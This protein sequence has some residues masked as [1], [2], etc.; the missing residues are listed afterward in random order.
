MPVNAETKPVSG[1][2]EQVAIGD[3]KLVLH[4]KIDTG[5]KNSSLN[6]KDFRI[7]TKQGEDWVSFSIRS[8]AGVTR[9][10]EAPVERIASIKQKNSKPSKERPVI[11]LDVCLGNIL[12]KVEVNLVDRENFDYQVLIGRSF[13]AGS[14]VVDSG[15]KYL[16]ELN[17]SF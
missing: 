17:C 3:A 5:A 16:T 12:K 7:F 14:F 9:V 13:L 11:M 6:A 15:S 8:K 4:A 1:W 2:V 10:I